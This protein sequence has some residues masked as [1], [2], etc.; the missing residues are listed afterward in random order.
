M[1]TERTR[2]EGEDCVLRSRETG[3]VGLASHMR[4]PEDTG[5]EQVDDRVQPVAGITFLHENTRKLTKPHVI[6]ALPLPLPL[7]LLCELQLSP[8]VIKRKRK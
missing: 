4:R 6:T 3:R 1:Q 2:Q 5:G 8:F 7:H